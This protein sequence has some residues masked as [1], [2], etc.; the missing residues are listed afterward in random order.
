M[1]LAAIDFMPPLNCSIGDIARAASDRRT[2]DGIAGIFVTVDAAA[3]GSAAIGLVATLG[4]I[5]GRPPPNPGKALAPAEA[6]P[7]TSE[8]AAVGAIGIAAVVEARGAVVEASVG[9]AAL[10]AA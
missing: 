6:P 9:A 5:E 3:L 2:T 7:P 8:D 1:G 4:T 10:A